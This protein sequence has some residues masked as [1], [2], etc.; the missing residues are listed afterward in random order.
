LKIGPFKNRAL[1]GAAAVS[2][3]LIALVTFLPPVAAAFGLT[4]LAP[5]LY[6]LA[7]ALAFAPVVVMEAVKFF[8]RPHAR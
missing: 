1:T 4:S 8:M 6:A 3:L 7:L 5:G 2:I